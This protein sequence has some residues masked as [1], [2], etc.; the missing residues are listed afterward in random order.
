M[1]S[2]NLACSQSRFRDHSDDYFEEKCEHKLGRR[3]LPNHSVSSNIF[4]PRKVLPRPQSPDCH[5]MYKCPFCTA[6]E[7]RACRLDYKRSKI[8]Y[9]MGQKQGESFWM[10]IFFLIR[11]KS[12]FVSL[13][14]NLRRFKPRY[15]FLFSVLAGPRI[16]SR[17]RTQVC[18]STSS[19]LAPMFFRVLAS[20]DTRVLAPNEKRKTL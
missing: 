6:K 8:W 19:L 20:Y 14:I 2:R 11:S 18:G 13:I 4:Q 5:V 1:V 12:G 9:E 7:E 17:T 10:L 16:R 15:S 3:Y